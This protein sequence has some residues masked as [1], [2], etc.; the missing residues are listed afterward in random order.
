MTHFCFYPAVCTGN[1]DYLS[2]ASC[3][4]HI[5]A[6]F[7]NPEIPRNS[8]TANFLHVLAY[9]SAI[10]IPLLRYKSNPSRISLQSHFE[11]R[12]ISKK[13][14]RRSSWFVNGVSSTF[15]TISIIER[16]FENFHVFPILYGI[17]FAK[18]CVKFIAIVRA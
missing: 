13:G 7:F 11:S 6:I 8:P 5:S 15:A 3:R 4:R 12:D 16:L 1:I 17:I 14:H 2:A 18:K 10:C 9:I